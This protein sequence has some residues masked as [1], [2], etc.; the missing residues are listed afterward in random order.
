MMA[1]R[2][3]DKSAATAADRAPKPVMEASATIT[4]SDI[5]RRAYDHYLARGCG[6]GHA[7]ED[8]LHAERELRNAA[9]ATA[10]AA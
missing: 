5:A 3:T 8:W 4:D 2:R 10:A 7:L 9:S 6:H 1:K